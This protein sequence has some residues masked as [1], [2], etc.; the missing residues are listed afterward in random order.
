MLRGRGREL[1]GVV[2]PH[3]GTVWALAR[4]SDPGPLLARAITVGR[5]RLAPVL[6][7]TTPV[8]DA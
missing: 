1:L 7:R 4:P 3:R 5:Q 8:A 6:K 2:K